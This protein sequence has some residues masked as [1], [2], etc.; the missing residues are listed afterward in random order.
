MEKETLKKDEII[1]GCGKLYITEFNGDKYEDI[2]KD[3]VIEVEDN[4]TGYSQ[5]GFSF[6]Y[7]P[8]EYEVK[9]S[10]GEIVKRFI[11]SEEATCKTGI[12]TWN[13]KML[14]RIHPVKYEEDESKKT[15]KI[16]FGGA[17][18]LKNVLVRFVH[19]KEGN[20]KLR[21]T[22]IGNCGSGFSMTFEGEKET[23]IDAEIKA[24]NA[25]DGFLAEFREEI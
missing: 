21:L 15:R 9:N 22:M 25:I 11:V 12:L 19:E 6:E 20:K 24:I 23:V 4:D 17:K 18:A 8:T 10:C 7:K 2:P 16:T 3:D 1:M 13:P 5:G 14:S